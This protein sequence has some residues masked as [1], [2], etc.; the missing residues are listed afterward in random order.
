MVFRC[1]STLVMTNWILPIAHR[2]TEVSFSFQL[3]LSLLCD[4]IVTESFPSLKMYGRVNIGCKPTHSSP[5]SLCFIQ[6]LPFVLWY[7]SDPFCGI[8]SHS[9][10]IY[11]RQHIMLTILHSKT[12]V[13]TSSV[14]FLHRSAY[15]LRG[16][17][18]ANIF[19]R[20]KFFL[21]RRFHSGYGSDDA[22]RM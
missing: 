2:G 14:S 11:L 10:A 19:D 4:I 21:Y 9:D 18:P 20:Q 8:T 22:W 12:T 6:A 15:R 17:L 5:C 1:S 7:R 3:R 16:L 13:F